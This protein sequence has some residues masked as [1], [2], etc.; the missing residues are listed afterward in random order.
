MHNNRSISS[1]DMPLVITIKPEKLVSYGVRIFLILS[2]STNL[3]FG[4]MVDLC[5]NNGLC[6]TSK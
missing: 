2:K 3:L 4:Q 1:G 6:H 5:T